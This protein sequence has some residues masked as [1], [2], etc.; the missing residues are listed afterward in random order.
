ML[1]SKYK[2]SKL[3]SYGIKLT[4]EHTTSKRVDL[5]ETARMDE[6]SVSAFAHFVQY[7]KQFVCRSPIKITD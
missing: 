5:F 1:S 3:A 2:A 6:N 4:V 7:V